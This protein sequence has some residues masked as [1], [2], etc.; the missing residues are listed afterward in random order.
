MKKYKKSSM[1]KSQKNSIKEI[2]YLVD[3]FKRLD[4]FYIPQYHRCP[5]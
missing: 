1:T 4:K 3:Q 2:L 5:N